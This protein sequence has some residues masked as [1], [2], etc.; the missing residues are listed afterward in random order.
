ME[1]TNKRHSILVVDDEET[2]LFGMCDY[3]LAHGYQVDCARALVEAQTLLEQNTYSL[4]IADLR[5]TGS[6][7]TEGLELAEYI[8]VNAP[9]T[10]IILLTAYGNQEI[11]MKARR[12]GVDAFLNKPKPMAEMAQIV[13]LLLAQQS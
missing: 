7:T 11:E 4:V 6:A 12:R 3:F 1:S 10:R 2:I 13:S 9:H 8:R 5:L